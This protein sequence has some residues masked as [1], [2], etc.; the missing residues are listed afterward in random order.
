MA[1]QSIVCPHC[2]KK[3]LLSKALTGQI[4]EKLRKDFE[5]EAKKRE[6]EMENGYNQKLAAAKRQAE[7]KAKDSLAVDLAE[8]RQQVSE[9]DDQLEKARGQELGLRKRQRELEDKEKAM[10]L[11]LARKV[12]EERRKVEG[13]VVARLT[14]ENRARDLA[15]DKKLA[16]LTKE[17]E[18]LKRSAE[19]GSQQTQGEAIEEELERILCANFP[20]D[21]IEPVA[22]GVKGADI[23]Q[24]VNTSSGQPCGTI[25]WEAKNT[26]NWND[27]W[28]PKLK[29]DQRVLRAEIAVLASMVL[30]KGISHFANIDGV[31]VTDFS[32]VLGVASALRA[33][34]TEVALTKFAAEGKSSKMEVLY[35][36]LSG[37]EFKQRVEAI[38]ESFVSMNE[39]LA[40]EKR[41]MET[42]WSKR[43]KQIQRVIQNVAG[44]Y[45]DM[46]GIIGATLPQIESLE[47]PTPPAALPEQT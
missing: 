7:K 35:G 10:D 33:N 34:L 13:E 31:W 36:Y 5:A 40:R 19:Q 28:I 8:L 32:T 14:E 39:D 17:I 3:I 27:E 25:I 6:T 44:M 41:A 46:K 12:D 38:V 24:C 11:E 1:E 4:E 42:A 23:V 26:K 2:K 15:K 37:V 18:D 30:P 20:Y 45:G 22:K 9:K 21:Q 29:D 47:L 43:E 16:D